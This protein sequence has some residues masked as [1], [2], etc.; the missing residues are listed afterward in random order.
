M[1]ATNYYVS[2]TRL[3]LQ[4]DPD[5]PSTWQ[6]LYRMLPTLRNSLSCTVCDMLLVEPY[7]P[8]ETVCEHHVCKSCKGGVKTLKPTC[9]W[10]KDYSKYNENVQLRILIQV[11]KCLDVTWIIL[12]YILELQEIMWVDKDYEDVGSH[13]EAGGAGAHHQRYH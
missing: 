13:N 11:R 3:V 10:C 1:N 6:D 2:T 5:T 9:S 4:G 7:T 8:E 12:A